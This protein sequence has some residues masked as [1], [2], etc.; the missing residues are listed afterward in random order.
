MRTIDSSG[1]TVSGSCAMLTSRTDMCI[2]I[3][4]PSMG[5]RSGD[6]E[7]LWRMRRRSLAAR[8]CDG[9]RLRALFC[10]EQAETAYFA[11]F[12]LPPGLITSFTYAGRVE[13]HGRNDMRPDKGL[14]VGAASSQ[15]CEFALAFISKCLQS[16]LRVPSCASLRFLPSQFPP[17]APDASIAFPSPPAYTHLP[18][19]SRPTSHTPAPLV[20]PS[21]LPSIPYPLPARPSVFHSAPGTSAPLPLPLHLHPSN[22]PSLRVCIPCLDVQ[23]HLCGRPSCPAYHALCFP[24]VPSRLPLLRRARST[25]V[26]FT[27]DSRTAEDLGRTLWNPSEPE[28]VFAWTPSAAA[29]G[30]PL[31]SLCRRVLCTVCTPRRAIHLTLSRPPLWP[32]AHPVSLTPLIVLIFSLPTS[33][34]PVHR[35]RAFYCRVSFGALRPISSP[36]NHRAPSVPVASSELQARLVRIRHCFQLSR[37][38]QSSIPSSRNTSSSSALSAVDDRVG[39][40]KWVNAQRRLSPAIG[41]LCSLYVMLQPCSAGSGGSELRMAPC[42]WV[43]MQPTDLRPESEICISGQG[44]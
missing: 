41:I 21:A 25:L 33:R 6:S 38:C 11:E 30:A 44:L 42:G 18:Q 35:L 10:A 2:H 24:A 1:R 28:P 13:D 37:R 19:R 36:P 5:A 9:I 16:D 39:R 23:P 32:V 27:G 29:A 17:H 7:A 20:A 40:M 34:R 3:P 43:C 22:M 14:C 26:V 8:F 15:C 31:T 4:Y 12:A